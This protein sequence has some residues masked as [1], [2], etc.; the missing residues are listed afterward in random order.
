LEHLLR[1]WKAE[2]SHGEMTIAFLTVYLRF[3]YKEF[4]SEEEIREITRNLGGGRNKL[5]AE[6]V[7][8]YFRS[9]C[10]G[11]ITID[12]LLLSFLREKQVIFKEFSQ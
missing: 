2:G 1:D 5:E 6:K 8:K 10:R 7:F 9:L 4:A 3:H 12:M 11:E